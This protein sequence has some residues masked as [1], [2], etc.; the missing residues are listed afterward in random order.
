MRGDRKRD[1]PEKLCPV[2]GRP[3]AWRKRWEKN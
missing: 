2:C 1:S 3:F